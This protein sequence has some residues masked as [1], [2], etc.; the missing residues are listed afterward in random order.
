MS[1]T[2]LDDIQSSVCSL[3][4][5]IFDLQQENHRL[6]RKIKKLQNDIKKLFNNNKSKK[7][8]I[9]FI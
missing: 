4:V 8:K 6:K 5:M 7:P 9:L 2:I 3:R 1:D